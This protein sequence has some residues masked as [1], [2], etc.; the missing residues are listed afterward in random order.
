M[1]RPLLSESLKMFL[2]LCPALGA[3]I[4]YLYAASKLDRDMR[5]RH[6]ATWDQIVGERGIH[7]SSNAFRLFLRSKELRV[8]DD[9]EISRQLDLIR[10]TFWAFLLG[11]IF[12]FLFA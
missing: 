3:Y 1:P 4:A 5:A 6:P 11:L 9:E 7:S 12:A 8:L 10:Y 2:M